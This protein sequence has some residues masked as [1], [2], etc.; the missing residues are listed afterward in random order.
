MRCTLQP[1]VD[2]YQ[3]LS[4]VRKD[5]D[6]TLVAL[7]ADYLKLMHVLDIPIREICLQCLLQTTKLHLVYVALEYVKVV[8]LV[9]PGLSLLKSLL[10]LHL[11]QDVM[12]HDLMRS[13]WNVRVK[14][15]LQYALVIILVNE[16]EAL[17]PW[18]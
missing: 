6:H 18:S 4:I 2:D 9:S 15:R 1:F 13:D 14:V 16:E 10:L 12:V 8:I 3:L 11:G 7:L 17:F 5:S